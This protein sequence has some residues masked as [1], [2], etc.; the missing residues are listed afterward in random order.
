MNRDVICRTTP[1]MAQEFY[2]DNYFDYEQG[3]SEPI[4]KGRLRASSQY[5]ESI[6]ASQF[7]L[8]IINQVYKLLFL[9]TP[10]KAVLRIISQL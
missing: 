10:P 1:G 4:V 5:W 8:D 3:N 7:V 6:G 9:D 2:M